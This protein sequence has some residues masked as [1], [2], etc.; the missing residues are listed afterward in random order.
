MTT[1]I[2]LGEAIPQPCP[3]AYHILSPYQYPWMSLNYFLAMWFFSKCVSASFQRYSTVYA[4]MSIDKQRNCDTYVL[5]IVAT[6]LALIGQCI[7]GREIL[8]QLKDLSQVEDPYRV[9][10]WASF[11]NICI[12]S[13]YIFELSYRIHFG[14]PLLVHHL[15]T[16]LLCQ[17][18]LP[19]IFSGQD[20]QKVVQYLRLA[21][22]LGFYA[23]L[24]RT[25]FVALLL[26]RFQYFLWAKRF[27]QIAL[28]QTVVLKTLIT[29]SALVY[30]IAFYL[31]GE[32]EG[33]S[34]FW[35]IAFIPLLLTLYASQVFSMKILYILGNRNYIAHRLSIAGV[36]RTLE[37]SMEGV[38]HSLEYGKN[39]DIEKGGGESQGAYN[40]A[41]DNSSGEEL[42]SASA[43]AP[44]MS[45]S[46]MHE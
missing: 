2:S 17:L 35:A 37:E 28:V 45:S 25:S 29:G 11:A 26:H 46:S 10:Q 27:F 19:A 38:E 32:Y 7:S 1:T 33:W 9:L 20:P 12:A 4:S 18:I 13:L 40:T 3:E 8:F 14:W 24:E 31:D 16:I 6:T 5:E 21:L 43:P 42:E 44:S 41:Q 30:F 39:H 23:T 15:A 34:K 22:L 36:D